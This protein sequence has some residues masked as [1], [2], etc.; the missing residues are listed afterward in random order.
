[1]MR[2]VHAAALIC[3]GIAVTACAPFG[4]KACPGGYGGCSAPM[5][6]CYPYP[7]VPSDQECPKVKR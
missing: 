3:A 6:N 1:M 2:A 5:T 7:D 4:G